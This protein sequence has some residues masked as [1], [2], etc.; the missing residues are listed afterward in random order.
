MKTLW[1]NSGIKW[2]MIRLLVF[3]WIVPLAAATVLVTVVMSVRLSKQMRETV[4]N[5]LSKVAS[6]I[7]AGFDECNKASRDATYLGV[8]Q[9]AYNEYLNTYDEQKL[10]N[11]ITVF[12]TGQYRYNKRSDCVMLIFT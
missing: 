9:E 6:L 3:G 4:T 8:V 10:Y 12:L 11:D 1:K 7:G 5:S 2:R